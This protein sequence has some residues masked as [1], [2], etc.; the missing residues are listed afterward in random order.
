MKQRITA[1]D[2]K[3]LIIELEPLIKGYRLNN[4]YNLASNNRSFLLKFALPD[5][6]VNVAIESGFK[7]YA[8]EYQRPT[9]PQP[10]SFCTKLRKHLKSKRLTNIRQLGDDRIVVLEFGD[11]FYYLVLE[12][13]SAGN[14][15]LLDSDFKILSLLRIVENHHRSTDKG[16]DF[17]YDIGQVYPAFDASLFEN[18]LA[19]RDLHEYTKDQV[20][21][22]TNE[23]KRIQEAIT[24]KKKKVLSINKLCFLNAPY[25][26]S[27][28][29]QISL[30][31]NGV[32]SSQSCMSIL[33]DDVLCS[34]VVQSLQESETRLKSLLD[35]PPGEVDGFVLSKV[36][37][38]FDESKLESE[39]NLKYVY[40]EFH[41]F[42]PVH[43]IDSDNNCRIDTIKGYNKTLDKF[44]T[45]IEKT[46]VC[47]GKQQQ[48]A[49]AQKR[50]QLVKDENAKKLSHLTDMQ[51]LNRKKGYLITL[52]SSEIEDCRLSVQSLLDQQMDWQNIDKLIKVEQSR[53]NSAAKMIKS[54]NL[55]KNEITVA[56]PDEDVD[57]DNESESSEN[58][59]SSD[60][61]ESESSE[62]EVSSDE[63]AHSVN[64]VIDITQSAF[65]NSSRYFDAKKSAKDKQE[66][67]QKNAALAIK[68]SENKIAQDLRKIAKESKH[69]VDI[70]K[71]RTKYWFEKYFWFI[72]NDGYLCIA[73]KDAVQID[74][75]YYKQ[76]DNETDLLVSNNLENAL[77]VV[78][79]NPYKNK[80]VPPTTLYQAG[81]YSLTNTKAWDGKMSPS[82]WYVKG[83]EV[84]KKDF[85]GSIL[86]PGLL[87]VSKEKTF[88]P[89]C[90]IVMG[91]GLLW[92]PD[93]ETRRKYKEQK[94]LRD[95]EL[96]LEYAK[97][98]EGDRMKV[99]ELAEMLEKLKVK[100]EKEEKEEKKVLDGE[101]EKEGENEGKEVFYD[102]EKSVEPL[103]SQQT[104]IKIRGK[105]GK[106]K[107]MKKKY[108]D[109][110]ED[111]RKLRM[112]VL[113]TLKQSEENQNRPKNDSEKPADRR[114]VSG[115]R[116]ERKVLQQHHQLS[117]ILE[118]IAE[119]ETDKE[120]YYMSLA[121]LLSSPHKTDNIE[122]CIVVFMPWGALSRYAYKVKVQPGTLKK[123]KTLNGAIDYFKKETKKLMKQNSDWYDKNEIIGTINE[124]DYFMSMTG[125][126][127]KL[128]AVGNGNNKATG[129]G[130]KGRRK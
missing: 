37:P 60:E 61:N 20:I 73:G 68:N 10:S 96:G 24:K 116:K 65:A 129:R 103:P 122:D 23:S 56:I 35:T 100:E 47:L 29:I 102:Q 109:Q 58:E 98:S 16:D 107:K 86:P 2:L 87:N 22:W 55:L 67:T 110:D 114:E 13:F 12:F 33:E 108:G 66:K 127:Y 63:N 21:E 94:I 72:S 123:G 3:L 5:S 57:D 81:I 4:I 45:M 30:T 125:S 99:K 39:Q 6:K 36:N 82:P 126:R 18:E 49:T 17:T 120:P 53:G 76:F 46:K 101:E 113:G 80:E 104:Q 88:M 89:P 121:E 128:V 74:S 69:E 118:E 40:E 97:A 7:V 62:N 105:K 28:L 117:R 9:L 8:T 90:Q 27:D 42:E 31:R 70:K 64:I 19:K 59:V 15:I 26:S 44:F 85:D 115:N 84:S 130:S 11:G 32:T 38:L 51:E 25:L 111:E 14:I 95:D 50:L 54:L 112:A 71:L 78:V 92:V 75:I 34:K 79:K 1:L 91:L 83:N 41:P 119:G 124:Q 43:R 52:H 93:E 77:E 48:Q 106:L